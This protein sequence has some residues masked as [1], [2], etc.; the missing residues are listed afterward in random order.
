MLGLPADKNFIQN[1]SVRLTVLVSDK[2]GICFISEWLSDLRLPLTVNNIRL[3]F[4]F[5]IL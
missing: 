3:R 5:F 2:T 1:V 4:S